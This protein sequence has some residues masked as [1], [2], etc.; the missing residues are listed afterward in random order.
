[1]ILRQARIVDARAICAIINAVIRDTLLTFAS[2]ERTEA[3]LCADIVLRG[4]AFLVAEDN[5][6]VV[7]YATY[8]GFRAGQGYARTK[9]LSIHLAEGARGQG[10]GRALMEALQDAA[11]AQGI[12]VLVAG[13]S[14]ANTQ[15][16]AFHAACGFKAMGEMAQVG[17]KSGQYLDL[18]LMQKILVPVEAGDDSAHLSD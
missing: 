9:E 13:I 2:K 7:G 10:T 14:S 6:K 11:R 15:G 3:E 4:S 18:V 16:I 5:G 1:M 12:H 8:G 17:Y